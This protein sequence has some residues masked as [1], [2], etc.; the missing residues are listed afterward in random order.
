MKITD[1][2][3]KTL[4]S[5]YQTF[6]KDSK[7]QKMKDIPMHRGSNCFEHCFKVAR[8]A[9]R[10]AIKYHYKK[11]NLNVVLIGAILHD[12]YLYDWRKDSSKRKRHGRDHSYIASE[13]ASRDFDVSKKVKKVIETHM[14]PLNISDFPETKEAR[15]V[16]VSDKAVTIG[17]ILTS[18]RYKQKRREKY[19]KN[20]S[21]LFD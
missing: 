17:E 12:Y 2:E 5:I 21:T 14:W 20:I 10:H 6:L 18:I 3:K 19:L 4:E 8:K 15:I 16:S 1:E 13:N 7:I 9:V 11:I